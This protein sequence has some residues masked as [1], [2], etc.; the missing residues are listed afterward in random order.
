MLFCLPSGSYPPPGTESLQV[1]IDPSMP[2]GP[3]LAGLSAIPRLCRGPGKRRNRKSEADAK[4]T[5]PVSRLIVHLERAAETR[6]VASYGRAEGVVCEESQ[7]VC[8]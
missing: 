5:C 4:T 8:P 6:R 2:G 1:K 3:A 7:D